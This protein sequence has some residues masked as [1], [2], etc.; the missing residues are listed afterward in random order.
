MNYEEMRKKYFETMGFTEE[1]KNDTSEDSKLSKALEVA[2]D[3]RKFEI[4]LYW[5]RATYF[6]VFIAL[7]FTGYA[8]IYLNKNEFLND[9]DFMTIRTLVSGYGM[10]F[11]FSWY[12]VNRG[13]K[14]WHNNWERH[15][16]FLENDL[17]GNLYKTVISKD[18]LSK[19]NPFSEYAF[20]VSK[21]NL[22]LS[23]SIFFLWIFVFLRDVIDFYKVLDVSIYTVCFVIIILSVLVFIIKIWYSTASNKI[24]TLVFK[25]RKDN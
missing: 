14:F 2:L 17:I 6:W 5:K 12:I 4:E 15:V 13:S 18:N 20:S 23:F 10:I 22:L 7:A 8:L 1:E 19:Y 24:N 21:V 9:L 11:S 3:I 16:D 25:N